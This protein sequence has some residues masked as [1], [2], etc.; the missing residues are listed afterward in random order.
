LIQHFW[1]YKLRFVSSS[2]HPFLYKEEKAIVEH[3]LYSSNGL[4]IQRALPANMDMGRIFLLTQ[5]NMISASSWMRCINKNK[6]EKTHLEK[7]SIL[8]NLNVK[9]LENSPCIWA[10][11]TH[12][13]GGHW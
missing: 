8:L 4:F 10:S 6:N 3:W 2:I 13:T 1:A 9:L 7:W 5:T 12:N 11:Y